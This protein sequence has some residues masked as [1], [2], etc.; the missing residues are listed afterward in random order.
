LELT[1]IRALR[2]PNRWTRHTALELLVSLP[3]DEHAIDATPGFEARLRTRFP[4]MGPLRFRG[5]PNPVTSAHVLETAALHLQAAAGCPV[6]FGH[7]APID[8]NGLYHVVVEYTEEEVGRLAVTMAEQLFAAARA[9]TPFDVDAAL[10]QLRDLY[11]DIRMGPS[12]GAI[13][14]AAR[15]RGIPFR[16]LTRGSLIQ[17][18]WGSRQRRIQAAETDGTGAIAEAIAQDKDLTKQLLT[19]AGLPVPD[20]ASVRTLDAAVATMVRLGGAVV[21][22][23]RDGSQGRGV[24]TNVTNRLQMATAFRAAQAHDADVIVERFVPGDD[25]RL[26]VVGDRLVAAA[27]RESP[28]VIGDGMHTVGELVATMN[29]DP[30]RGIG[31]ATPLTRIRL[32]E[33][34]IDCLRSQGHGPDT[35]PQRGERVL[36]RNNANLSTGGTATDVTDNVHPEVARRAVEAARMVGLDICGVDVVCESVLQPLEHQG[37]AIV[38]VNAVPG[39]RMHL[40]PSYGRGRDIGGAV[41]RHMFGAHDDARIPVVAVTGTNGKTTT[42]RLVARMVAAT[43]LRVGMTTTD[44]VFV[45]GVQIDSGDCSG[46]RSA[47]NVLGHPEVDA[48]V[49]ET[50]RGGLLR[51]GLG[52]DRCTVGVVTNLGRGDHLG[53]NHIDTV[54]ALARVKQ[55]VV[56]NVAPNGTAVLNATDPR[57]VAMAG[58]CPGGVL[59]FG[60]RAGVPV[61]VEHRARG[62]RAVFIADGDIVAAEGRTEVRR[63]PL[64]AVP[65]TRNGTLHFQVDNVLAAVG[66]AWALGLA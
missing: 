24:T 52:F 44:G 39:L 49:L 37:G 16:R 22:K 32:D 11:E 1:R 58:A 12:T 4:K 9:D 59:F 50:A 20:G 8:R 54:D 45:D 5:D 61:M 7:T 18:G 47:R 64:A 48:A 33:I 43:G 19:A 34:A 36:L 57:V 21:V 13:A 40:D 56:Q 41:V 55:V 25:H 23:P 38:E 30:R 53:L 3:P 6:T 51:E 26:L 27:R 15:S 60:R 62:K 42:V 10:L 29:A 46:P 28:N 35:V 2:G 14:Q 65:L 31:H 63:I 17:F 66:A